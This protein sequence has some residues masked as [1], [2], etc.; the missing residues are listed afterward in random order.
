[1]SEPVVYLTYAELE[2]LIAKTREVATEQD[3]L[4]VALM[5]NIGL[6]PGEVYAL[7]VGDVDLRARR[8]HI[9]RTLTTD[10]KRTVVGSSPKTRAGIR[11][12]PIAPHLVDALRAQIGRRPK[13]ATVFPT[14]TGTPLNPSNWRHR[15]FNPAVKAA[16][17]PGG[18]TPKGLRHTAASLAIAAG[19]DVLMVQRMLGHADAKETLNTYAKLFPDRLDEVSERMSKAREK[20]LKRVQTKTTKH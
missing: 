2:R 15:A 14:S 9:S 19:A 20:A 1:M 11:A 12:V 7:A 10:G 16:G 18:L 5:G 13:T 3:A 4:M 17:L 6:R 8:I